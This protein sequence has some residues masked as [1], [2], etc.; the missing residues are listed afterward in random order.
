MFIL[1]NLDDMEMKSIIIDVISCVVEFNPSFV[2]E[3]ICKQANSV[4]EVA[5]FFQVINWFCIDQIDA[6]N[7]ADFL[8]T[9]GCE[10]IR[11]VL[12]RYQG[13]G[14]TIYLTFSD[15]ISVLF[16]PQC[17]EGLQPSP[18]IQ[19]TFYMVNPL[20]IFFVSIFFVLYR[21][22]KNVQKTTKHC[23]ADEI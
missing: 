5:I 2:R 23:Q 20:Y 17:V 3:Y 13:F 6:T 15:N 12:G 8:Q 14:S 21:S 16:G 18:Y 9:L 4:D 7:V 22:K 19:T 1:Q 11:Q 10:D